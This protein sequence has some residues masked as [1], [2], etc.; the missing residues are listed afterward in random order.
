MVFDRAGRAVRSFT[1]RGGHTFEWRYAYDS[2]NRLLTREYYLDG[3]QQTTRGKVAATWNAQGSLGSL[4]A[5]GVK[6]S[7]TLN[8]ELL[9]TQRSF[10][11][12]SGGATFSVTVDPDSNHAGGREVFSRSGLN[13]AFG[14]DFERDAVDRLTESNAV[15]SGLTYRYRRFTYDGLGRL[16]RACVYEAILFF[17]GECEDEYGDVDEDTYAYDAAGNRTDADANA[18]IGAG[19]RVQQFRGYA[20]TYDADGNTL[21]KVGNGESWAYVYDGLGR[22]TQVKLGGATQATYAYDAL[23]RRVTKNLIV[24]TSTTEWLVYD[25]DQL[26]LVS[27]TSGQ[28]QEEYGWL[29]GST[30]L[31]MNLAADTLV[32]VNDVQLGV[33]VQGMVRLG[34]G[35]LVK[36]YELTPWGEPVVADTGLGVRVR[37][38]GHQYDRE[39]G[40][41]W[42]RARF[43]DPETGRF[44]TEDPIGI[45]GGMNLYAYAASDPV[46][47]HDPTGTHLECWWEYTPGYTYTSDDPTSRLD[48]VHV[49]ADKME[50]KC[51]YSGIPTAVG[52]SEGGFYTGAYKGPTVRFSPGELS[53]LGKFVAEHPGCIAASAGLAA[54][55]TVDIASA[56]GLGFAFRSLRVGVRGT[57]TARRMVDGTV[58]RLQAEAAAARA[59]SQSGLEAGLTGFSATTAARIEALSPDSYVG[60]I[61]ALLPGAPTVRGVLSVN[62][63]CFE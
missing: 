22:L 50:K 43:Y 26:A 11:R 14:G 13:Q 57:R 60:L 12:A 28:V 35:S 8:A 36:R 23:G 59:A 47:A 5:A 9:A 44:L 19:N 2:Q 31:G 54:G 21:T 30:L 3:V 55:L 27:N 40:L 38:G 20:F 18:V 34:S 17:S 24:P 32:A 16:K 62:A 53:P 7:F 29:G 63:E 56:A 42:M 37:F 51:R 4:T 58:S 45:A 41:Y 1:V 48:Q 61:E 25:G 39:S 15:Q 6:A 33:T 10:G 52:G 49:V 46:N